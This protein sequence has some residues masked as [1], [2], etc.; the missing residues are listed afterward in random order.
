VDVVKFSE[1]RHLPLVA[2][3]FVFAWKIFKQARQGGAVLA[4]DPLGI[5]LPALVAARLAKAPFF[6]RIVGDR[7][8][9][10]VQSKPVRPGH[11]GGA[12][13]AKCK[14][15]LEQFQQEKFGP[16]IELRRRLQRFVTVRSEK[17]IVPSEY[18]KRIVQMWGVDSAKIALV[19]NSF[20]LPQVEFT[21]DHARKNL[22]LEGK[23]ILSAGRLV[24]WKG[25]D[26]LIEIVPQ[27]LKRVPGIKLFIAGDGPEKSKYEV[28][29]MK[30][31]LEEKVFL[32][33]KL[34][35]Q[36]LFMYIKAADV[37]V[38]NT[39]YEGLSHQL[40]EVM[41]L[42]TPIITTNI[43]G[44]IELIENEKNGLLVDYNNEE[45]LKNAIIKV[46]SN[47]ELADSLAN[48]AR[49]KI[50]AFDTDKMITRLLEVLN[51]KYNIQNTDL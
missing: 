47:S 26:T 42:G 29:S 32:L 4:L 39:G 34:S 50:H 25:M 43:G 7:A 24:P 5:G 11:P 16:K 35:Q 49:H 44:N 27:L 48:E 18:L 8:W 9:E 30:Y 20:E 12:Q 17:V 22:G 6:V 14:I 36:E 31:G 33:G 2:R 13:S 28:R 46:L 21:K 3:H 45:Q 23:I 19:Q 51:T 41:A 15:S 38:L 1:V 37:F 40:L 10:T